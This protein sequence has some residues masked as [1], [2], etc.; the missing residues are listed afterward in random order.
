MRV[1]TRILLLVVSALLGMLIIAGVSLSVLHT[2]METERRSQ[3]KTLVELGRATLAHFHKMEQ[4]GTLSREQAQNLA[5]QAISGLRQ[6]DR[7]LWVRDSATD[8]NLVHPDSKRVGKRDS[9]AKEKGDEYRNALKGAD[10]GFLIGEGTRPGVKGNVRKLYTVTLFGP[11]DWIV[12]YGG[13]LDDIDQLFIDRAAIML[14]IGGALFIVIGLLA[15]RMFRVILGELGGEPHYAS[16]IALEI[17]KGNLAGDILVD[18]KPGSLLGSMARMQTGLRELVG[19]F[20]NAA[21]LLTSTTSQ[22][23]AQVEMLSNGSKRTSAAASSTAASVEEMTVSVDQISSHAH[24]TEGFS[25]AASSLAIEGEHLVVDTKE[26]IGMVAQSIREAADNI[27]RLAERSREIDGTSAI[28]KEIADQTNLLALNAAI[29][30]ARA[31]EQGRGF[32]VVADEVRKLAER[33]THATEG[34]NKTI[35]SVLSDTETAALHME[36]VRNQ[37]ALSV[38]R[39]EKAADALRA[40]NERVTSSLQKTRDVADAAREQSQ[41]SNSIAGNVEQIV[42]MVDESDAAVAHLKEQVSRLDDLAGDLYAT[43]KRFTL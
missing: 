22:L 24:E 36:E 21:A 6:D 19:R 16:R 27:R 17:A 8:V 5:K 12:G 15:F 4:D 20:D 43:A 34:I 28:I 10:V 9:N 42:Q 18:G 29:E 26:E 2:S 41:A 37:V 32:A 1:K 11:W 31:G 25:S 23:T 38:E 39:A 13:Y 33:T 40:I 14:G 30:A 3:Q 7:Y 35:R